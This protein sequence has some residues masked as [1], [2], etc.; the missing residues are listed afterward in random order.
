MFFT[1]RIISVKGYLEIYM[2]IKRDYPVIQNELMIGTA[3]TYFS[4]ITAF[5]HLTL[6]FPSPALDDI[7][8]ESPAF[9]I[10]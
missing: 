6:G 2:S 7:L 3:K 5:K 8:N 10:F 4:L 1:E 9:H